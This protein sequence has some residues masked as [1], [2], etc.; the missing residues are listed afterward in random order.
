[1]I[2]ESKK[3]IKSVLGKKLDIKN[4]GVKVDFM[5]GYLE[6]EIGCHS[7]VQNFEYLVLVIT[8]YTGNYSDHRT[9]TSITDD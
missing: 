7:T 6:I 8:L 5:T 2:T 3:R 4:G 1:M 9:L